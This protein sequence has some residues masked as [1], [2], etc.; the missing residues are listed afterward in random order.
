MKRAGVPLEHQGPRI[1]P[2]MAIAKIDCLCAVAVR[3]GRVLV[4]GGF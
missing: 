1:K 2:E 3:F 4:D